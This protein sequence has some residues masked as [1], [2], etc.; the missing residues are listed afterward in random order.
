VGAV[1]AISPALA[2]CAAKTARIGC[3]GHRAD[4]VDE[5]AVGPAA[6]VL[7]TP[8]GGFGASGTTATLT[9]AVRP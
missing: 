2:I 9:S 8:F 7:Q 1:P 6:P 3:V 5:A 4:D